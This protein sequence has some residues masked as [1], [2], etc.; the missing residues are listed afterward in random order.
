MAFFINASQAGIPKGLKK[1]RKF[2][3]GGGVNDFGIW[4][5]WGVENFGISKGGGGGKMFMQPA[6]GYGYFLESPI[7]LHFIFFIGSTVCCYPT[8]SASLQLQIFFSGINDSLVVTVD[9]HTQQPCIIIY[10]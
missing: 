8:K 6:A 10:L 5:A 9:P 2:W 1:N 7:K 3:R 4:R